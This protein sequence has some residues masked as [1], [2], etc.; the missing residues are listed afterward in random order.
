MIVINT[1]ATANDGTGD[2]LRD[3]FIIVNQNFLDIQGILDIVLTDSSII[4][5]SQISGLQTI[6]DD[7]SYQ[8]SLIP[9][10]QDDI[11]SINSTIFTINQTLNSQNSSINELY[12]LVNDLQQQIFTKIGEAPIDGQQ[13]VRQDAEWVVST[14]V[15]FSQLLENVTPDGYL[16]L[17]LQPASASNNGFYINKSTNQSVGYYVRNTDNVGNA[18]VSALY[19][20]GSGGLYD[21][22]VS[23]FHANAGYS[24]P[25]LRN[26]NG[27]ISNN[28][29]F[30]IGWQGA[31]FD[32]VT[33]T[34]TFGNETS[35]FKITNSGTVSIGVQPTLDN[36]TTDILGRKADGTIV[37]L[38]KSSIGGTGSYLPLAGGTMSADA[39]IFFAN[40]SKISEGLVDAGGDKGIA[41]TCAV[42]YEWKWEAGEAYLTNLS[43]N[44]VELKQYARTIP[45]ENDD[46]TKG[47]TG[48]SYW[49]TLGGQIYQC[50][51]ATEGAAVWVSAEDY[52]NLQIVTDN[53]NTTTNTIRINP[54]G[55]PG[56]VIL[57][58]D[59]I[60]G[61]N[62]NTSGISIT[63]GSGQS[64][65]IT[66]TDFTFTKENAEP[67][68]KILS[69]GAA[70]NATSSVQFDLPDKVDAT[71]TLATTVDLPTK[72]SDLINDGEDGINPFITLEDLP[73][74]SLD[75]L[76]DV[77]ITSPTNNQ[78]PA[79]E[80]ATS[81]WKNKSI[82]DLIE[83]FNR[84]QGVYYFE[85]FM[86]NQGGA[87]I[88]AYSNVITL[89]SGNGTA[90]SVAT[91]NRTNQQ[92]IIQHSTGTA[93]TNFSGYIYGSSLYIGSG[94][95]SIETYVTIDT[96]SN[97]T[98]R[99]FTYFGYAG[100]N[101]NWL[102]IPSGIFFSYDEGGVVF[103]GGI[104][105]PN[106]K[107]YTRAGSTVTMT[108]T[109]IPVVDGQW[110]KL[111]IDINAD[112]TSVTFYVDGVLVATH[113]T[114]IPSST[115]VI[116]PISIINK[117][118]GTTARTMLT[119]Y[120][121]YEEIFTNAR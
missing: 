82:L 27:L 23:L 81:L 99:F 52:G 111:R 108:I 29:L 48:G 64:M 14:G 26:N 94:T 116:A 40:G 89:V 88:A 15:T 51:D 46:I 87:L 43:G 31:S 36:D 70:T 119:D 117:S 11:N 19:L 30:F 69:K 24:I 49:L 34:G 77:E 28:D 10:L 38:D 17:R 113:T 121:M 79:Y 54:G 67:G 55:N 106:W 13:Y 73:V 60:T 104:A 22:Y 112:G 86:G 33:S 57:D 47:F 8:V 74:L 118:A 93:A 115:T 110:Y 50:Q 68:F 91:T 105:T 32:F 92:G 56:L 84:T 102:N 4:P 109:T 18:A 90:R 65:T 1:G 85:E 75:E 20:G 12:S 39:D 58:A 3:A 80:S 5:I 7:L 103:S 61:I 72:T 59:E 35:K 37:R 78:I 41:L 76:T 95:I 53:G 45:L 16:G 101:S 42:G 66:P 21:N 62:A 98:Q 9:T 100:G 6:L 107:C 25:Y 71:Y 120:F 114:N 44:I 96:L 63:G 97:A 2:K 83:D